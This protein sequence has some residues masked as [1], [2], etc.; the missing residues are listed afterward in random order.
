MEIKKELM[1]IRVS[2]TWSKKDLGKY[3]FTRIDEE[4]FKITH[5]TEERYFSRNEILTNSEPKYMRRVFGDKYQELKNRQNIK[6]IRIEI[7]EE[8]EKTIPERY[9]NYLSISPERAYLLGG[10]VD[11]PYIHF[12]FKSR[13]TYLVPSREDLPQPPIIKIHSKALFGAGYKMICNISVKENKFASVESW[14]R[15]H[16]G[17]FSGAPQNMIQNIKG[18]ENI[19]LEIN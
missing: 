5:D 2:S 14:I 11:S 4:L 18:K 6:K 12:D 7:T 3:A 16:T 9:F 8:L 19:W 15:Y 1:D 10:F 17:T 13:N